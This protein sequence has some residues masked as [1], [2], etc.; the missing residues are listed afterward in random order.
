MI[1][2]MERAVNQMRQVTLQGVGFAIDDFGTG[3]ASLRY[4]QLL[5]AR[6]LKIDRSFVDGTPTNDRDASITRATIALGRSLGM[7]IVAEGVETRDQA[8]FLLREG[9][10]Y[11][12]G[13]LFA[14][15]MPMNDV[16]GFIERQGRPGR[17]GTA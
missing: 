3:H 16:Q 13:W 15:P 2:E 17:Q 9:A 4:L 10:H 12:Q 6:V 8:R 7:K 5:P 11:G 14:R 1:S